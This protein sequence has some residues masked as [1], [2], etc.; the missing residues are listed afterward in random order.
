MAFIATAPDEK[1]KSETL[2]VVRT[3]TDDTNQRDEYAIIVRSDMKGKGL[4]RLLMEKMVRYCTNR[5]SRE[6]WGL[7]L[8][9]NEAMLGL[10]N[11][12]GFKAAPSSETSAYKVTLKLPPK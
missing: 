6:I 1:G 12:L 2:G 11:S 3:I 7:V 4:G 9:N 5:G 8:K 10:V